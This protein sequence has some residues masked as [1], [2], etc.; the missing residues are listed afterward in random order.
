MQTS[1]QLVVLLQS[2]SLV[3]LEATG[4]LLLGIEHDQETN[5]P[6]RNMSS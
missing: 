4:P 1:D 6:A 3:A 5:Q 2:R